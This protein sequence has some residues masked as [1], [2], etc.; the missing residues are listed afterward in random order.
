[1]NK[2]K[3]Y[4]FEII[5][6]ETEN[7]DKICSTITA[8]DY[9]FEELKGR[10]ADLE[11]LN[12]KDI[13]LDHLPKKELE[14]QYKKDMEEACKHYENHFKNPDTYG[15]SSP[16]KTNNTETYYE[17]VDDGEIFIKDKKTNS[18]YNVNMQKFKDE[19]YFVFAYTEEIMN[20]LV[21]K[22]CF[23]KIYKE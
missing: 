8:C 14:K 16:Q 4:V 3:K 18:F 15:I 6:R 13:L 19:G 12:C 9:T 21:K 20:R 5:V 1:M 10:K 11:I 22:G 17:R 7:L 2:D 23:R